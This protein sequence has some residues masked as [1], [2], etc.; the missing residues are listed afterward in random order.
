MKEELKKDLNDLVM[1]W[2]ER[3]TAW[4]ECW[5]NMRFSMDKNEQDLRKRNLSRSMIYR[6][7]S[8]EL[9]KVLSH[10]EKP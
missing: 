1:S 3:A 7:C 10:Y 8:D 4:Q 6:D 2:E 5:I 9:Q